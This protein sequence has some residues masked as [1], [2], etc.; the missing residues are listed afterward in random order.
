AWDAAGYDR[1]VLDSPNA[2]PRLRFGTWVGGDRDGH[3]L[4]TADVTRDTLSELRRNALV[5]L[6]QELSDLARALP[7]SSSVQSPSA[8]LQ[9]RIEEYAALLGPA[10]AT[11]VAQRRDEPWRQY[12]LLLRARLPLADHRDNTAA[13]VESPTAY[14]HAH[15]LQSDLELLHESLQE[16][17]AHRID[18][19]AVW[20]VRRS[21]DVFGFH[22]A[23]LDIRQNSAFHDKALAQILTAAGLPGSDFADWPEERRLEFLSKELTSPRPFLYGDTGIGTEADAVLACYGVIRAH[24]RE[25]GPEGLGSLIVSMTRSVSDLLVVYILARE[26][27]LTRWKDGVLACDLPAVPLF[28]T[29]DDLQRS[30]DLMRVFLQHPVTKASLEHHLA[31]RRSHFARTAT[32]PV[33]QVM[34]GYSD[35]NKDCGILASQWTLYLAQR[36]LTAAG[37]DCGVQIRFFHGRGGT[38]SRGAGPTHRFLEALPAHTIQGDFRLTEQGETIAQKYGTVSIAA[39]NLE[40]LVGGVAAASLE[41][42]AGKT[43]PR[44]DVD[45][46]WTVLDAASTSVYQ[47][48]IRSEGFIDFYS[49]ATPIDALENTRIGSRP[50]RRTGKRSLADLRAIPW[51]FSWNQSRTYLP[52][53]FGVGSGLQALAD[54]KP[55]LFAKISEDIRSRPVL[56]YVLTNVETNLASADREIMSEYAALVPDEKIRDHFLG[57]ILDEFDLTKRMLDDIFQGAV[58]KRRPRMIKTLE[59]RADALR[60]LHRRQIA[61]LKEWRAAD[62]ERAQAI[63]PRVLLSINA[64]ASGLRTTG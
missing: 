14:R 50:A 34:I 44:P 30:P 8:N 4:V 16:I 60:V 36:E 48:F 31:I 25:Y 15:E 12:V 42:S 62:S 18:R 29:Q 19:S 6:D 20:P 47:D 27:G 40:L 26:A 24:L 21:L 39:H 54:Q 7:L 53:W 22:L 61:L 2:W 13:L 51:V 59:L 64:I 32:R 1:K 43:V 46:I 63:L 11:I 52:G 45:A 35:S 9:A 28:E 10:A 37:N 57:R 3:P 55:D 17:D 49:Y 23:S 41:Q 33:Q 5:V 56:Y 38:I 58:E